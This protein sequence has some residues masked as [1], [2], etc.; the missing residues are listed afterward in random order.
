MCGHGAILANYL[1]RGIRNKM[2]K[3]RYSALHKYP[4]MSRV[5]RAS[6]EHRM[7]SEQAKEYRDILSRAV[8]SPLLRTKVSALIAVRIFYAKRCMYGES[9][10]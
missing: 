3:W 6:C 9:E 5:T 4:N 10:K 2:P 1:Y 7:K 8:M